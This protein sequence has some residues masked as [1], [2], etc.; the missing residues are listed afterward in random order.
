MRF[1]DWAIVLA[2]LLGPVLA[3]QAQ[4]W[5][6]RVR[7]RNGRKEHIFQTIMTTRG[8]RVSAEHVRALNMI[9]LAFTGIRVFGTQYRGSSEQ[10]V[11]D[12][13]RVYHDHLNSLP[14]NAGQEQ[15]LAWDRR[16]TEL[17]VDLL[18]AMAKDLNYHF[19]R[20][21]LLKGVYVPKAHGDA[22]AE[23]QVMR[24]LFAQAMLNINEAAAASRPRAVVP[25]LRN[26][27][28]QPA[29]TDARENRAGGGPA[30]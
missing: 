14:E 26:Q 4:K 10:A 2:T 25:P 17:L 16:C 24:R 18:V 15:A 12:A 23:Q 19:D 27:E 6:E 7:A 21:Q 22:E 29:H 30:G 28:G 3:V 11:V 1:S 9:D 8:H 5:I 20:V 13:W